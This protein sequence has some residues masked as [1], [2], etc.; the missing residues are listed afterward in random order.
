MKQGYISIYRKMQNSWFWRVKPFSPGQA[1]VDMLLDA[2]HSA[3][4]ILFNGKI[5]KIER[6]SFVTSLEALKIRWG[7]SRK[8]L[9]RW[10]GRWT[11]S[12]QLVSQNLSY[13]GTRITICNYDTYQNGGTAKEQAKEQ[14]REQ[15][16]DS[17]G[18]INNND[19]KD[20]TDNTYKKK[21]KLTSKEE[22]LQSL[23]E[24]RSN[25]PDKEQWLQSLSKEYSDLNIDRSLRKIYDYWC[26]DE[27]YARKMKSKA[28]TI[29]WK[30][31]FKNGLNM[32]F[33]Q[34]PK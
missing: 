8:K 34:V 18:T 13:K 33:N 1:W 19:N 4:E 24:W 25:I 20:N 26:T 30:A 11:E 22:Y 21:K 28:R 31:T 32:D 6:G 7:W 2:N 16:G 9:N 5:L 17:R 15:P 29:D 10:V 23:N 3:A 14:A 12:G 27:G